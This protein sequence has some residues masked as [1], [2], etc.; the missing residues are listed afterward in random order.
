MLTYVLYS[1]IIV[2]MIKN[3]IIRIGC[4]ASSSI[5]S[6]VDSIRASVGFHDLVYTLL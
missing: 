3:A 6:A 2:N 5:S 4:Y 1:A